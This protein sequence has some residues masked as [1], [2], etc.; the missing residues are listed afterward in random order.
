MYAIFIRHNL[1]FI[2]LVLDVSGKLRNTYSI[3]I[4]MSLSGILK[5]NY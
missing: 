3:G 4:N 5:P 1:L 2:G